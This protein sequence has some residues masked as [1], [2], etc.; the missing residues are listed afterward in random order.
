MLQLS[1]TAAV[2][3]HDKDINS[4]AVAPNDSM[5]A[6]ASQD[7]TVKVWRLPSLTLSVTLRGHKR[8]VWSVTFSPVDQVLLTSSGDKTIK[9]WSLGDGRC[10]KTF[11]GHT[12][13]VLR[14]AFATAGT[15][16]LSSG[17]PLK[18]MSQANNTWEA[19]CGIAAVSVC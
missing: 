3:A 1:T 8:G 12:G 19:D 7:R 6:T 10:L 11:E 17:E 9:M 13:G 14:C 4:V 5:L 2:A 16:V 15:Q 18:G